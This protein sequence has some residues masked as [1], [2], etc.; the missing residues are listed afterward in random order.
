MHISDI[1][2]SSF[3]SKLPLFYSLKE[4]VNSF[5]KNPF[6]LGSIEV[7]N[8][9]I[10]DN[11]FLA[12]KQF[13][14]ASELNLRS[15]IASI[16]FSYQFNNIYPSFL[17]QNFSGVFKV[18][19][20]KE[21]LLNNVKK[22]LT[23]QFDIEKILLKDFDFKQLFHQYAESKLALIKGSIKSLSGLQSLINKV[24]NISTEEF[25]YLTKTQI[26]EK[27]N[28]KHLMDSLLSSK[29]KLLRELETNENSNNK[30]EQQLESITTTINAANEAIEKILSAKD[31]FETGG[32]NYNQLVNYQNSVNNNIDSITHSDQFVQQASK[33][34]LKLNG[35]TKFFM[36]VK[37]MN[38]GKFS[39]NW[40]ERSMSD[41]LT[42]GMGGSYLKNN[43]FLGINISKIQPLGWIK[44]NQILASFQQP[45][46]AIQSLRIGKGELKNNHSHL[47][48]TNGNI[49]N[50][51]AQQ[52]IYS[53]LPRNVFV[54]SFSKNLS[55][56]SF[57]NVETEVSKSSTQHSGTRNFQN[58]NQVEPKLALMHLGEDFFRL[59]Q[60]DLN[61]M[62][63]S[64][65]FIL[66]HLFL[67]IIQAWDILTQL[68]LRKAG[69][70][71]HM[72]LICQRIFFKHTYSAH[73]VFQKNQ[74]HFNYRG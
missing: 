63:T 56:G 62:A 31:D 74:P 33:K 22:Q 46:A 16:P 32:L 44:D 15:T 30:I 29:Q 41:I 64:T 72:V 70:Q 39:V 19:F 3:L 53:L 17:E 1:S 18:S 66:S 38:L 52:A 9:T 35:L 11:Y 20:E 73:Q 47:T 36:Y 71:F 7:T 26:G 34:L 28:D 61:I 58:E 57:G 5:A 25:L 8:Q 27:L 23:G 12:D 42:S 65:R 6:S 4:K 54:G 45:E 48:F 51:N 69:V 40:S 43:K 50:M 59:Y 49:K 60:L 37:E 24:N 67:Q 68:L 13:L 2:P 21:I 55:L 14:N 10:Y